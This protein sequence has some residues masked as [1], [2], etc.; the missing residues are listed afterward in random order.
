MNHQL[1]LTRSPDGINPWR[2][3]S[4]KTSMKPKWMEKRFY[5]SDR[6]DIISLSVTT[7]T[8]AVPFGGFMVNGKVL[9]A[10]RLAT[11]KSAK[12]R[13]LEYNLSRLSFKNLLS[14]GYCQA[15]GVP[16]S[17]N[18]VD[19]EAHPPTMMTIDRIDCNKGYVKGNVQAVCYAYNTIKGQYENPKNRKY[20]PNG[21]ISKSLERFIRAEARKQVK[22]YLE[23]LGKC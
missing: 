17:G 1:R 22:E 19:H 15:T 2:T 21:E 6:S 20:Q 3:L 23:N 4:I 11:R 12:K 9:T 10:R 5:F 14:A 7:G 8:R 13:G 16:L 18:P